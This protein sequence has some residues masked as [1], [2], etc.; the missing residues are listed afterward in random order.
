[1]GSGGGGGGGGGG[2]SGNSGNTGA[3]EKTTTAV[4]GA[5]TPESSDDDNCKWATSLRPCT[6]ICIYSIL[7][8]LATK[9]NGKSKAK[10]SE[11]EGE[12]Q[13]G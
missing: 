5:G 1:V 3:N 13:P 11:Y 4:P 9:R 10:Q 8:F 2:N 6:Y 12:F 7:P